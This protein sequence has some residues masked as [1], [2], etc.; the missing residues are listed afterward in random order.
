MTHKRT[1]LGIALAT[2]GALADTQA[3]D[4]PNWRGPSGDGVAEGVRYPI[5]WDEETNVK[6]RVD[7][8][9]PGNS[10]PIISG[11]RVFISQPVAD[12]N[13]RT[14]MAFDRQT[15]ETLWQKG[16]VYDKE[17]TTHRTNPYCSASPSTDGER[18]V[19]TFGSAG[20]YCYSVEGEPLWERDLGPQVHIWGNA[21][22]PVIHENVVIIYHGPG[23]FSRMVALDLATG[24]IVWEAEDP[25]IVTKGRTD[26]FRGQEPGNTGSFSTPMLLPSPNG[27][28]LVMSYHNQLVSMNPATGETYWTANGLNPLVYTSTVSDGETIVAMGGY[29]GNSIAISAWGEGQRDEEI[30]WKNQRDAGGVGTGILYEGHVYFADMRGFGYCYDFETGEEVWMERLRAEGANTAYWGSMVRVDDRL[31]LT[32]QSSETFVL[33]ASPEFEIIRVN[34]LDGATC[35][36]TPAMADGEIVLRNHEGLWMISEGTDVASAF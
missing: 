23:E 31:Y 25:A 27:A 24:A 26:G 8:P 5:Q 32:N 7:L 22:S 10:S 3:E 6:W 36:S 16:V 18:V 15:G 14:V 2:A 13:R 29:S 19:A 34:P 21:S 9:G 12:E 17:E 30:L 1:I 11:S 35:N 4:W 28:Q 20:V 33:R